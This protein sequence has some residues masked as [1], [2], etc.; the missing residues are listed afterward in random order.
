LST[1]AASP[2]IAEQ[3]SPTPS[4]SVSA[5][6]DT[7]PRRRMLAGRYNA[8]ALRANLLAPGKW[9]PFP[10]WADRAAWGALPAEGSESVKKSA[11]A[12]EGQPYAVLPATLFLDYAR[13]GNRSRFE[14]AQFGRR[15]HLRALVLAECI[16]G[17]GRL[18]DQIADGVWAICEE[19]FWGVPAHMGAQKRGVGLPDVN[20]PIIDLFAAET[21]AGLAWVD[22]LVGPQLDTVHKLIR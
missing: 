13:D 8:A 11:A 14:N 15:T 2:L 19:S 21:A 16:E 18:V 5:A 10:Q 1:A 9:R 20:E 6:Q 17:K 4:R 7:V 12:Y 22:Y 3:Q